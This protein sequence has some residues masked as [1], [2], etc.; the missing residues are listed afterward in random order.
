MIGWINLVKGGRGLERG[1]VATS[2]LLP[3]SS[4]NLNS[5]PKISMA[6]IMNDYCPTN[7]A[8][9]IHR[10]ER[11]EH[12]HSQISGSMPYLSVASLVSQMESPNRGQ[13]ALSEFYNSDALF[14][15]TI[16]VVADIQERVVW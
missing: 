4:P 14:G 9:T 15:F 16:G 1:L 2:Q 3:N 7:M 13:D 5:K 11:R 8:G 6:L 10:H 12:V